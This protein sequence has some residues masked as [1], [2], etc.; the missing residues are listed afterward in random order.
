MIFAPGTATPTDTKHSKMLIAFLDVL[1]HFPANKRHN[2]YDIRVL[3]WIAIIL[4]VKLEFYV[5][6]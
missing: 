1:R 3:H 2:K 4:M 5:N 6:Y